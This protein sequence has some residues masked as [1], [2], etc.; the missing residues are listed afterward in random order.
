MSGIDIIFSTSEPREV[1]FEFKGQKVIVKVK[2]MGWSEKNKILSRCFTYSSDGKASFDF[3]QYNKEM[4]KKL[5]LG[6]K[7]GESD[8]PSGEIN[9]IFF[10]RL[11]PTFGG[12]LQ[13]LVPQAF[14]E[15]SSD[16]FAKG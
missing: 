4:L 3:D 10:A 13:R 11:N 1:E 6:I 7:V 16:F 8:V 12:M 2:E 9:E 15:M 5:V 14:E